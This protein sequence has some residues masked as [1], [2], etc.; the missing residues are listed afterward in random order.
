MLRLG[1]S[2]ANLMPGEIS[3]LNHVARFRQRQEVHAA[4]RP[5]GL[6]YHCDRAQWAS[7][8]DLSRLTFRQHDNIPK[9]IQQCRYPGLITFLAKENRCICTLRVRGMRGNS[10]LLQ[11]VYLHFARSSSSNAN[12]ETHQRSMSGGCLL[13][14]CKFPSAAI[15]S[16]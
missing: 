4:D 6:L 15:P 8:R 5:S 7:P 11:Q 12:P 1:R 3:D 9:T 16:E 10:Q 2:A 14:I 13:D